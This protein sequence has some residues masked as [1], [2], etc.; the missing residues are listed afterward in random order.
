MGL[1]ICVRG[2]MVTLLLSLALICQAVAQDKADALVGEKTM[3][4]SLPSTQD[5]LATYGT[6]YYGRY[7]LVITFF[8]AAFT[9]V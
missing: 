3:N 6:D 4:F 8:P 1:Q 5:R 7:Y 9:P 2:F